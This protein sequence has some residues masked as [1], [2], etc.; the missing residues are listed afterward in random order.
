MP[1]YYLCHWLACSIVFAPLPFKQLIKRRSWFINT[2]RAHLGWLSPND[3]YASFFASLFD[4]KRLPSASVD[5][6]ISKIPHVPFP[7]VSHKCFFHPF[8]GQKIA[9][10]ATEICQKK[11][12]ILIMVKYLH[13]E[14]EKTQIDADQ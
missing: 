7:I 11:C 5:F 6:R 10:F 3:T 2:A 14:Q 4:F 13:L 1:P 12:S 9:L 8:L